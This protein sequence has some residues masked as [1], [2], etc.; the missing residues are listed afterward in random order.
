MDISSALWN[1]G[2]TDTSCLML[3]FFEE[4]ELKIPQLIGAALEK[5]ILRVSDCAGFKGKK[6]KNIAF[7]PVGI[8]QKRVV[9]WG[10]GKKKDFSFK[11]LREEGGSIGKYASGLETEE[12]SV[13]LPPVISDSFGVKEVTG[14]LFEGIVLGTYKFDKLKTKKDDDD[15]SI[16]IKKILFFLETKEAV[17]KAEKAFKNAEIICDSVVFGRDLVSHPGN[18]M[19]PSMLADSA[20]SLADKHGFSCEVWDKK[21][22]EDMK[23]GS[24]L[25]VSQGSEEEPRFI[26]LD[27]KPKVSNPKTVVLV[28]KGITFDSGGISLKPSNDM[29]KMKTDMGGASVVISAIAGAA[30]MELP[31]RVVALIPAAENMPSGTACKPGDVL[32]SMSG[33]TVEVLNTDAEGRLI[34]S[35]ALHHAR[36]YKPDVIIDF[37]TLTGACMVALGVDTIGIMGS[38]KALIEKIEAS[39]KCTDELVWELPFNDDFRDELKSDVADLKNIG[40]RYGGA[41]TAGAFLSYFVEDIPWVH[42]DIAGPTW[43]DKDKPV[44]PKGATGAGIRMLINLLSNYKS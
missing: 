19:T 20:K 1:G 39:A 4:N 15:K 33:K 10:L 30:R 25:G 22:I 24:L 28:G 16:E 41:M 29:D 11:K 31:V 5:E 17:D 38:D 40:S 26:I 43:S 35:D 7:Y 12:F 42:C 23:M 3:P 27:Y 9:L 6:G 2:S 36:S 14:L 44:S 18:L 13:F 21:K 34:L 8:P 32:T 37:A